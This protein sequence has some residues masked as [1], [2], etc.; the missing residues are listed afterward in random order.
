MIALVLA[1]FLVYKTI[2]VW[3]QR[4]QR[5]GRWWFDLGLAALA[6]IGLVVAV[7][8]DLVAQKCFALLV[9]PAGVCW[10]ALGVAAGICWHGR[11][12]ALAWLLTAVFALYFLAGNAWVGK[13]LMAILESGI[14]PV[15]PVTVSAFDAVLVLG[16]GTEWDAFGQPGLGEAGDRVAVAA[17]LFHAG[18]TPVLV[19]SG[20]SIAGMD[21]PRDFAAD[22]AVLWRGLG[23][24]ESAI[25]R[26]PPGLLVTTDEIVAYRELVEH[27]GWKRVGL[28]SSAWHLPR[29]LR[30]ARRA[31]LDLVPIPADRHGRGLPWSPVW[32]IPQERGFRNVQLACWEFLGMMVGR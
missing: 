3:R 10:V 17:R 21:E 32:L 30:L 2:L 11:R 18:K 27:R 29:A 19:A 25:I 23:I 9:M 5:D 22:T 15:D 4:R 31:G 6:L 26:L 12:W 20:S 7:R 24:P 28:V 14:P 8:L 13:G 1:A 16:G